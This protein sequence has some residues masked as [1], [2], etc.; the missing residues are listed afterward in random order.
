MYKNTFIGS[1]LVALLYVCTAQAALPDYL[2]EEWRKSPYPAKGQTVTVN[3]SP[4]LWPSARYWEKREVSYNVY[5]SQDS[6]FPAD[7]TY[8]SLN[9][10][11]CMYNPH[12]KLEEGKWFWKYE[13]VENGKVIPKGTY[14]FHVASGTEGTVTPDFRSFVENIMKEHPRV[15]NYGRSMEE[16]HAKAPSHPLYAKMIRE[17]EKVVAAEP[18]RGAVS[19]ANP[20]KARRLSQKAGKE[21]EAFRCLLEGYT[22]SGKKEMRDAL[23][24]RTD[25]LLTWPTD[26]LLGSK[27]LTSLAL[28]Y[29]MLYE[30]LDA[31]VKEQILQTID[32]QFQAG[33]KKWPG[34]TEARQVE[35]HF[36]QM[37]I[38]G[39]FTAALATLH[40]LE[41]AEKMLEYTY[42][43]FIARFPN[44][45]TP[46]GGW[47]EGE[48]YYS[49]NQSAIV[50]MALLLK[51]IGH[52]D[53]FQTEWYRNL[54]DYFTY[55]SPVAAPVSGF[56]DMHDRV[57][58][59]SL[60]GK[61]EMLVIGCEEKNP[62]A[63]YRLFT[64]LRPV[65]SY[66]GSPLEQGYWKS[67]LAKIEQWYQIVNDIRL[68]D[69]DVR[70]P[71][72]LPHDKVFEGVGAAALH[73][74]VLDPAQNT[75]VFFRS[76]PFGAKGHMH[77]NQNSFNISR[78]G[79]RV[80]YST[81][82][83]TSFAD[84]HALTSYRHTRAHNTI[85]LNG[86]G[87]AFGHEG[88]GWIK[89]H[90]EGSGMSYVC[91]DASR[92]YQE[93]TDR[94]FLDLMKQNGIEQNAHFGMGKSGMKKYERHLVFVRP[95][96]V[97]VYDVLQ[98]EQPSEWSLLLHT[99]QLSSLD[100][101]GRLEVQT[102]R[103]MAQAQVYGS[104]A[105]KAEVSDRYF[106][107]A[108]D[109]KKKYK[110]GT[111][112]AYHATFKNEEK[113]ADMRLLTFI[114]LGDKGGSLPE[115]KPEGKGCWRIGEVS[116]QAELDGK[117]APRAIVR[118]KDQVLEITADK[119]LLKDGKQ[120]KVAENLQPVGNYAF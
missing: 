2:Y 13:E 115:I 109:F 57:A 100:K 41:S 69:K 16:I 47:A 17:A 60:K 44:L 20:A 85:L 61:S 107:P 79:E 83:Y 23:L 63:I 58:S 4:L 62:E 94:Q 39:N 14:S 101:E 98:A 7:R 15:M 78:K 34:Y 112:P 22:L 5:L 73:V 82:Y 93:V 120:Q 3:P 81:G 37:E 43:L 89:R 67:P 36:W 21:V 56:G 53:I 11:Y 25:I 35:N 19:D 108:V 40:H 59:G 27:V 87:Q 105:L 66:Y 8:R 102:A 77:A 52:I 106:S 97:V 6:L 49:V 88:Y 46:E 32:K 65:D 45:A 86:Y 119:T 113:V 117:K 10:K 90:L 72:H 29:D 30:E 96:L 24:E 84:P 103:S 54:P 42:E 68:S 75:T 80:F 76:S 48:G 51:K 99:L 50:D 116:V 1:L 12:R 18:Y 118:Y 71:A 28:V 114:Q 64:S 26:D 31:K 110:Q 111:P 74:D 91:G 33:L 9:Q 70:K 92:A 55:F 38:A 104:T 95:D